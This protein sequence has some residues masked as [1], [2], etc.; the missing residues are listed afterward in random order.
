ME[1]WKV[2]FKSQELAKIYDEYLH[3]QERSLIFYLS[4]VVLSKHASFPDEHQDTKIKASDNFEDCATSIRAIGQIYDLIEDGRYDQLSRS[5]IVVSM[6]TA[7]GDFFGE[8]MR[9]LSLDEQAVKKTITIRQDNRADVVIKTAPL[10][11][12]HLADRTLNLN[13]RICDHYSSRWINCIINLRHMFVHDKGLFN[14]RYK[15]DMINVWDNLMAG[16]PITFDDNQVDTIL[17]F[18]N[19]HVKD[20]SSRLDKKLSLPA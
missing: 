10:K 19:D 16:E 14:P 12:A 8:V 9:L 7:L 4:S 5:F 3:S 20:F 15:A 1:R 11:I 2:D 17:W 6:V 13:S 18:F